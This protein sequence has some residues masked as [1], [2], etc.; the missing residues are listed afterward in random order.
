MQKTKK[1]FGTDGVRGLANVELTAQLAFDLGWAGA[2]VLTKQNK[3]PNILIATDTRISSGMLQAAICAGMCSVGANVH[4]AGVIPTPA[5]AYLVKKHRFD[6]G[7]MISASHNP[8]QDNGIKYFN[9]HGHKL[10]DEL[11]AEIED[12][13][14]KGEFN[15]TLSHEKIGKI[16]K[17]DTALTEYIDYLKD[18]LENI[19]FRGLCVALDCANGATYEAASAIFKELGAFVITLNN[20][21]DG[22]NINRN[23]GSTHMDNI[24]NYVKNSIIGMDIAFAYDGDGDRCFAVDE[25]GNIVDGDMIMSII[26]N[27]LKESGKLKKNTI[28]S[29]IMSNLGFFIMAKNQG[30]EALQAK[31]GDRY[32]LEKMLED[33]YNFGGEQSGHII[34]LDHATTGD[35]ILSSLMLTAVLMKKKQTLSKLNTL[36]KKMPQALINASVPNDAKVRVLSDVKLQESIKSLEKELEGYGRILVRPSGT[37]PLVRVMIEGEDLAKITNDAKSIADIMEKLV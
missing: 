19:D 6:A 23:C 15:P 8:Y 16:N 12:L 33:G 37:E 25:L 32:V 21:P 1:L 9:E 17:N 7:C 5:V 26:G 3:A 22:V 14:Y 29:T 34:F 13:I 24:V 35:G 11:E 2:K 18:T 10:S 28:V 27:H 30:I 36:M 4:V 31:V 20:T